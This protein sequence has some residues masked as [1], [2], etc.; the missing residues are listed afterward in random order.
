[1]NCYQHPDLAGSSLLPVTADR[2]LCT[3]CERPAEGTVFCQEHLPAANSSTATPRPDPGPNPYFQPS[4]SAV[5]IR[6][7]PGLAFILGLIPEWAPFTTA[8]I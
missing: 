4:A 7:S 6:T 1:M 8:S 5:P 3:A 2:G